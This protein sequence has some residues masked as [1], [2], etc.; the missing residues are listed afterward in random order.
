M[1]LYVTD[2]RNGQ[3][4]KW[5]PYSVP[6]TRF[7]PRDGL[8]DRWRGWPRCPVALP[9]ARL[10]G[11]PAARAEAGRLLLLART[12]TFFARWWCRRARPVARRVLCA[13]P[14]AALCVPCVVPVVVPLA[15][16]AVPD[17]APC[18]TSRYPWAVSLAWRASWWFGLQPV[19]P[20][21]LQ[22]KRQV[23]MQP[24]IQGKRVRCDDRPVSAPNVYSFSGSRFAA[25]SEH[26]TNVEGLVIDLDQL[27]RAVQAKLEFPPTELPFSAGGD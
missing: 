18:Q 22:T 1:R 14:D 4:G 8:S 19:T 16:F 12:I 24:R 23:Q 11:L 5:C 17:A 9:L 15:R 13:A 2:W 10:Y 26:V 7:L 25:L 20:S 3:N 6:C 21:E 27:G